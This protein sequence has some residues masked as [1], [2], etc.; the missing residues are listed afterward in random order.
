M[1]HIKHRRL[2]TESWVSFSQYL[3]NIP[4]TP[5]LS[6]QSYPPS[7]PVGNRLP[8]QCSHFTYLSSANK[9]KMK[10]WL[11]LCL[12]GFGTCEY[13]VLDS[14]CSGYFQSCCTDRVCRRTCYVCSTDYDCGT[15]EKCC[16][17]GDCKDSFDSCPVQVGVVVGAVLGVFSF[18]VIIISVVACCF[19]ACCPCYRGRPSGGAVIVAQPNPYQ[20]IVSTS[21]TV[22]QAV[23]QPYPTGG[24]QAP[25]AYPPPPPYA[26]P[27]S[28][29]PTAWRFNPLYRTRYEDGISGRY[30]VIWCVVAFTQNPL[31]QHLMTPY[32]ELKSDFSSP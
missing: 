21:T 13:C 3:S 6:S 27:T 29:Y 5:Q 11:L 4:L 7:T 31:K 10:L 8:T 2:L 19:C 1:W 22:N 9:R 25:T 20:Q 15:A 28:N 17:N 26:P 16:S 12:V 30:R 18:L 23:V 32:T 24:Y 14:D